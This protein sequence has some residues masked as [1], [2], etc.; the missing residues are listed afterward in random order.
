MDIPP[1]FQDGIYAA[2]RPARCPVIFDIPH[3]GR[4][5][6]ADFN[7]SCDAGM[8]RLVEDAWVDEL[9]E[10]PALASGA[11]VLKALFPRSYVDVNRAA[12]DLDPISVAQPFPLNP[13][14]KGLAGHGVFHTYIR[15]KMPIY[16]SPLTAQTINTR[17]NNYYYP[18]CKILG[19]LI[20]TTHQQFKTAL[21]IDCHSM[22]AASLARLFPGQEPD[23]VLGDR[24]GTSCDVHLRKHIQRLFTDM[25]YRVAVNVPYKGAEILKRFGKPAEG[26]HAIQIEISKRLYLNESGEKIDNKFNSLK[27][28][29]QKFV[30]GICATKF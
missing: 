26:I 18:Y 24:D 16:D 29:I 7:F 23:I 21:L 2:T 28:N 14:E 13:S 15:G 9:I 3:S 6:P 27:T 17:L 11:G 5:Y 1:L 30:D 22:P 25:G 12:D 4:V 10:A 20:Q 8:L 19:N